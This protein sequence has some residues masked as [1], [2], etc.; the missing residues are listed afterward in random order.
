[1][2]NETAAPAAP[3]PTNRLHQMTVSYSPHEDRLLLRFGTTTHLEY[4]LWL[5]RRL[6]RQVWETL[7]GA[8]ETTPEVR[9]QPERRVRQAVMSLR[10]QEAVQQG[11]FSQ[12]RD[13]EA[14]PHPNNE[15]PFLVTAVEAR[16]NEKGSTTVLFKVM[17][18]GQDVQLV[19]DEKLIHAL[20]HLLVSGAE[21][22]EWKLGLAM[23]G[24]DVLAVNASDRLH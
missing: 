4:R 24:P 7:V 3:A 21:K 22:A 12:Q 9:A 11:D 14:K 2:E 1:M 17:E 15:K 13:P 23:A 8:V 19:L 20:C 6:V 18:K 16:R 10:H 5:T